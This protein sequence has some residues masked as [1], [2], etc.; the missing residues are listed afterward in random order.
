MVHQVKNPAGILEDVDTSQGTPLNGLRISIAVSCG[1][2]C[3]LLWLWCSLAAAAP[4][5]PLAWELPYASVTTPPPPQK[6]RK[7]KSLI[8]PGSELGLDNIK[9]T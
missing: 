8:L 6:K 9:I 3:R 4:I 5:Q 7:N 1:G 2:N